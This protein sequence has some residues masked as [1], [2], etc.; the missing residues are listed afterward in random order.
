MNTAR[1]AM[2][3]T[4]VALS[5]LLAMP[6]GA[7]SSDRLEGK[8]VSIAQTNYKGRSAMQVIAAPEAADASSYA[9]VKELSFRDGTIEVDVA[10]QPAAG[11]ASGV[12]GFI[13]IAVRISVMGPTSTS[14]S[15]PPTAGRTIRSDAITPLNTVRTRISTSPDR[16]RRLL[17]S[18]SPMWI[19]NPVSG[20]G[21]RL[22]VEGRKARLYVH[23]AAQP[24]LIVN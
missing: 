12:R 7:Q 10:G 11:A 19:W 16:G 20:P 2:S 23:G 14:I 1:S 17:K 22:R 4:R 21:T 9:V 6:L 18:M 5:V 24:C 3:L 13:G 15:D 8:N